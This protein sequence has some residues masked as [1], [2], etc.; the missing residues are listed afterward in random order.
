M[1][2]QRALS[3][4]LESLSQGKNL[5]FTISDIS[6]IYPEKEYNALRVMVYRAEKND[7]IK[8]ICKGLYGYISNISDGLNL[9]RIASHLRY[10]SF[11]YLSLE[12]VLSEEGYISQIPINHIALMSSGRS[13]SYDCSP[14]G[15]VEFVHT[16]RSPGQVMS[17]LF[18][19]NALG[20]WRA[21]KELALYDLKRTGRY[22]DLLEDS[23]DPF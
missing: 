10:D 21:D 5:F 4:T 17:H 13:Y 6:A 8:R 7:Y 3:K 20:L 15:T 14:W 11:N 18:F 2:D 22:L 19:D 9:Y 16:T 23:N 12:S 1:T